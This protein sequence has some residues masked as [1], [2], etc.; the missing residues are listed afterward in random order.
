MHQDSTS[1]GNTWYK[2]AGGKTYGNY[3]SNYTG[4]DTDDPPDGVGDTRLPHLGV[5]SYPLINPWNTVHDVAVVS[6]APSVT[7]AYQGQ[8]VNITVV[9]RNEGTVNETFGITAKYFN[10]IIGTKV[11]TNLSRLRT[12]SVVFNWNTTNVPVGFEYEISAEA[13]PVVGETDHVDNA[14]DGG[15]VFLTIPGDIQGDTGG[16]PPD[17]DVDRYDFGAFSD[18]YPTS[19]GDPNYNSLADLTGDQPGTPADGDVDRYDYGEFSDNYGK[20]I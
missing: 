10:R 19:V 15:T 9:V 11:V 16:S 12:T 7:A 18:A 14:L 6:V 13:G 3:W 5:D 2:N 17:G 8:M 1:G 20:T 4:E